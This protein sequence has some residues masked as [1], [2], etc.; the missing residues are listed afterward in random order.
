VPLH[1][2]S[3][4]AYQLK[5]VNIHQQHVS[6]IQPAGFSTRFNENEDR[7]SFNAT[8]ETIRPTDLLTEY[9]AIRFRSDA[10]L[11]ITNL[12]FSLLLKEFLDKL[13]LDRVSSMN[14]MSFFH[15]FILEIGPTVYTYILVLCL[16]FYA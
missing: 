7:T 3:R 1:D 2:Q 15:S 5:C 8:I 9:I 10:G 6:M 11:Y 13:R 12:L 14:L 4:L 16:L